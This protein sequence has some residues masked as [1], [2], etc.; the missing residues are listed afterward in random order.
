MKTA[1]FWAITQRVVVNP[2]RRFGTDTSVQSS[3]VKN[4]RIFGSLTLKKTGPIC[5]S[6]TSIRTTRCVIA[7]KSA[8]LKFPKERRPQL[9]HKSRAIIRSLR[10]HVGSVWYI[11]HS[12]VKFQI[13]ICASNVRTPVLLLFSNLNPS[14]VERV[15]SDIGLSETSSITLHILWYHCYS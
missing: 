11:V 7:Q 6:E 5:Y 12:S 4:P 3:R 2:Y 14:R 13:H 8:V 9:T 10:G 1:L 15:Y